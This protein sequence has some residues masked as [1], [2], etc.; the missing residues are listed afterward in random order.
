MTVPV[1]NWRRVT[2]AVL[3]GEMV[4]IAV[5]VAIVALFG[6][7]DPVGAGEFAQRAGVWVGPLAGATVVLLLSAWAGRASSRPT[8]QGAM[9]GFMVAFLDLGIL[10]AT[11]APF[12]AV[13]VVS[14]VGKVVA[15]T[16][17]GWLSGRRS[18]PAAA[19]AV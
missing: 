18:P 8:R 16:L 5:L 17:G 6:P 15:G 4:P 11:G 14:N 13:F 9:I 3:L 1:V 10:A 19:S 7:R 12:A 2:A